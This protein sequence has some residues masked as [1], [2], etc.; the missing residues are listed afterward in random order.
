MSV[1]F[2]L[3]GPGIHMAEK[4]ADWAAFD[5]SRADQWHRSS[6]A[7][8]VNRLADGVADSGTYQD[9]PERWQRARDIRI[10]ANS[11]QNNG[12]SGGSVGELHWRLELEKPEAETETGEAA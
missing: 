4:I 9:R 8:R 6:L 7:G 1:K 2:S 11:I 12:A 3:S 10:V 5:L